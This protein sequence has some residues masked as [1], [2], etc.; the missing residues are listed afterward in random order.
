MNGKKITFSGDLDNFKTKDKGVT[1]QIKTTTDNLSLDKLNDIA[2]G[3]ITV[4]LESSQLELIEELD[5]EFEV[6]DIAMLD[7]LHR[8]DANGQRETKYTA[9]TKDGSVYGLAEDL[10]EV[11]KQKMPEEP[12]EPVDIDDDN[13]PEDND[14]DAKDDND[15][16]GI[17][18]FGINAETKKVEQVSE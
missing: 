11:L 3:K 17:D 16:D 15:N 13:V 8:I 6:S 12:E 4:Y 5:G 2:D 18:L 10:Y 1:I 9:T 7:K 14:S